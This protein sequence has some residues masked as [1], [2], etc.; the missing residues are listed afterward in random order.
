MFPSDKDRLRKFG[1][2]LALYVLSLWAWL[3]TKNDHSCGSFGIPDDVPTR[4]PW[5][6]PGPCA[7]LGH[8]SGDVLHRLSLGTGHFRAPL[9]YLG[10]SG[11]VRMPLGVEL[12]KVSVSTF[13]M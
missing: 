5:T 11:N 2:A 3:S 12:C 6:S 9:W 13:N 8:G 10:M 1:G 7:G 4:K